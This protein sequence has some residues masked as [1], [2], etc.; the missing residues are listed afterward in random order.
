MPFAGSDREIANVSGCLSERP[1]KWVERWDCNRAV[2]WNSEAEAWAC[3][4]D[5]SRETFNLFA[6]QVL[7]LL[8]GTSGIEAPITIDQL[9]PSDMPALPSDAAP[10][11]FHT[12]GY[13]I[14]ERNAAMGILGFGCS[15]LSCNGMAESIPVNDYCL[16]D[17][18]ESALAAARRFGVE[19][20]EPGPYVVVEVLARR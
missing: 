18:L 14:V 5:E 3:V 17:D 4:P 20:P 6:Y 7:P 11:H 16:V 8:F 10:L 9:F 2:C 15:P 19:Q 13:D 1:D 12:L